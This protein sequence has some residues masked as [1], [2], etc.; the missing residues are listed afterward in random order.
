M[1]HLHC[2]YSPLLFLW[3]SRRLHSRWRHSSRRGNRYS[4]GYPHSLPLFY[5]TLSTTLPFPFCIQPLSFP[6][7]RPISSFLSWAALGRCWNSNAWAFAF[8][9]WT[10]KIAS[11]GGQYVILLWQSVRMNF[12]VTL[13]MYIL[14][15]VLWCIWHKFIRR[16]SATLQKWLCLSPLFAGIHFPGFVKSSFSEWFFFWIL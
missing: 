15:I 8:M 11:S 9:S 4:S 10:R 2:L 3:Q 16:Y 6:H 1:I 14:R 12:I 7:F 13:R 5:S